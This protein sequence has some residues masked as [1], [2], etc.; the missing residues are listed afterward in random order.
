VEFLILSSSLANQRRR[1]GI[2]TQAVVEAAE[3]LGITH[4][5]KRRC[6]V[7]TTGVYLVDG[8]EKK[9][10]YNDWEKNW[11]QNEICECIMSSLRFLRKNNERNEILLTI[12]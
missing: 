2:I 8:R 12:S 7:L 4:I 9:L 1:E 6:N 11:G 10:L 5:V 3:K